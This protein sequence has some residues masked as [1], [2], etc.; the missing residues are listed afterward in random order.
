MIIYAL[1]LMLVMKKIEYLCSDCIFKFGK[2][3]DE[4]EYIY[5][6]KFL[7]VTFW[8]SILSR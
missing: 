7:I 4:H 8:G 5:S 6:T 2:D 1:S 3:V